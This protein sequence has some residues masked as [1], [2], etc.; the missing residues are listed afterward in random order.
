MKQI[1]NHNDDTTFHITVGAPPSGLRG[2]GF[3]WILTPHH[4]DAHQ[5]ASSC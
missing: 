4:N 1:P 5:S 2:W 3:R